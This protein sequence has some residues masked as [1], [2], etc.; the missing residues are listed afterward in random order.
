MKST[1]IKETTE[2]IIQLERKHGPENA[3]KIM[4]GFNA[5]FKVLAG[6]SEEVR[7]GIIRLRLDSRR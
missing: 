5:V 6:E 3:M 4:E 1:M 7:E 2:R